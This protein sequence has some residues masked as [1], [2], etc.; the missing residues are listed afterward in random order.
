M[1]IQ[2]P[3]E[4]EIDPLVVLWTSGANHHHWSF[5]VLRDTPY[6]IGDSIQLFHHAIQ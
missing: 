1:L 3:K 5:S 4:E 2:F 6:L